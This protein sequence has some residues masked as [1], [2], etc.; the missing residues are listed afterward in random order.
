MIRESCGP[1]SCWAHL[2]HHAG[3][4]TIILELDNRYIWVSASMV[5]VLFVCMGNICRSPTAHG[6]FESLITE[7]GFA[8]QIAVDSAGTHAYHMG[9]PPDPRAQAAAKQRGIDLAHL[10]ARKVVTEDFE[11]FDHVV[12]MDYDNLEIMR[13]LCPPGQEHKLSL[14]MEFAQEYD[15]SEVPDPYYGAKNGF[16]RVLDMVEVASQGLLAHIV[17]RLS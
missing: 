17:Q 5:K 9:D 15:E 16:E 13:S 7:R 1:L 4:I 6:V 3:S 12:V 11:I 2:Y 10:R 14:F 8:G